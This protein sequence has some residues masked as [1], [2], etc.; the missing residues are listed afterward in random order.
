MKKFNLLVLAILTIASLAVSACDKG[1]KSKAVIPVASAGSV[2]IISPKNGDVLNHG[3]DNK[4]TYN[5]HLGPNGNH[6]HIYVDGNPPIIDRDVSDCPCKITLPMLSA[7]SHTVALKVATAGHV[8][9]GVQ[10]T[11]KFTVK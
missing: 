11:V 7:G 9:T 8:L 6:L 3:A 2:T 10:G 1:A 5:V 4:L